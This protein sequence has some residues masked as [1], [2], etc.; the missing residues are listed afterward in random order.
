[1]SD[2]KY[3][4]L[5]DITQK[6]SKKSSTKNSH[7]LVSYLMVL[8]NYNC[9]KYMISNKVGIFRSTI[10]NKNV[11][12]PEHIP[13][14]V[15]KFIKIW[16]SSSGQ[17]IDGSDIANDNNIRHDLLDMDAYIHITSPIRRLVDLLNM[18]KF[19][20][21]MKIINLSGVSDAFYKKW[22]NELD[23][24]NVTMRSIRKLQIDC[25]LLEK[26]TNNMELMD[27]EYDGYIFDKI[28]RNDGLYQF[29]VF[30]PE[31]KLSSRITLRVNIENFENKKFKLF[32]F[33]DEEN[34]KK[35]IRLHL[36][37]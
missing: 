27:K 26:C 34:Y 2:K 23:Y 28:V 14:E 36:L 35:K 29:I 32:L 16:N 24:I 18:I 9:A 30:L 11:Y 20:E 7:D 21:T 15:S 22:I 10:M 17:Y 6:I 31:L 33:K 13:E 37:N 12:I 3:I 4:Q 8:M 1:M 25:T 5:L 19:Q